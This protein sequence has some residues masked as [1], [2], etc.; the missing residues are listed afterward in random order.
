MTETDPS[1]PVPVDE[2]RV[3]FPDEWH[4]FILDRR[5]RGTPRAVTIEPDAPQRMKALF[6][7]RAERLD[8][9]IDGLDVPA[10]APTIRAGIAGEADPQ[11]AALALLMFA[12]VA[13]GSHQDFEDLGRDAWIVTHGFAFACRAAVEMLGY[14][15]YYWNRSGGAYGRVSV[16]EPD[17]HR[18]ALLNAHLHRIARL[19]SL[20]AALPEDEYLAVRD[21]IAAHRTTDAKKFGA[22]MLMPDQEDWV[23]EALDLHKGSKRRRYGGQEL[24][25]TIVSTPE[26]AERAGATAIGVYGDVPE[27]IALVVDALGTDA[28]PILVNTIEGEDRPSTEVRDLL[29]DAIGR[30]PT[31]A[32]LAYLLGDLTNPHAMAAAVQAARRFPVRTLRAVLTIAANAHAATKIRLAGFARANGLL[33]VAEALND[34]DRDR[35][36]ELV[37]R[38]HPV[39][40]TVPEVFTT[41]PWTPYTKPASK[42]AALALTPPDL[43]ELRWAPGQ[44]DKWRELSGYAAGYWADPARWSHTRDAQD[45]KDWAFNH[46]IAYAPDDRTRPL[47]AKWDGTSESLTTA[48]LK[49]ILARYGDE[50][51][52]HVMALLKRKTSFREALQ[53]FVNLDAARLAAGWLSRSRNERAAARAWLDQYP[54]DA[55]AFLIPDAV[56]K[57][58]KLRKAAMDALRHLDRSVVDERAAAYGEEAAEAVAALLDAD[59]FDPQLP[60]IPK[61]GAW[62]DPGA[63]PQVLLADRSAALPDAAVRTL[64]TALAMD[65]TERPYPGVDALA[66]ECEPESLAAFSW[67]LF[68]LWLSSGSPSKDAWA[69]DQLQRFADDYAVRHLTERIREWPGQSQNRKAVRGLE[70]LGGVGSEAALRA[71]HGIA[72]KAKFKALKKTATEQIEVIAERLELTLDQLGDRLVPDFGLA[73]E[74]LV[75]DYGPRSFTIKFDEALKPY[76]IDDQGKRKASAPKPNAKDDPELAGPAYER[77]AALRKELKATAAEQVKRLEGAMGTGRTWTAAEFQEF[78]I[79]HPL[80]WQLSS[81]LVWQAGDVAFRL[82]EDRTL[83]DAEDEPFELP[84]DAVV[85]LAHPLTLGDEVEVW[86]SVF[87]DYEILQP[88]DQLA[89]PAFALTEEERSTGV[90][91]RFMGAKAGG[92]PL[93]G[94]IKR[95]WK[96]GGPPG[97][98]GYGLYLEFAGGGY[99]YLDSKPGVHPGYGYDNAEEQT[100]EIV[101]LSIPEG[102]NVDPVAISE[103]INVIAKLIRSA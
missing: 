46:L 98:G 99:L 102:A 86:A 62:A 77:F 84:E 91:K 75:L 79:D 29:F 101:E 71:V 90:L 16:V 37:T 53:P 50:V 21:A 103:A 18:V 65:Q 92:G 36:A 44:Q 74:S 17:A 96:Y 31:D 48:T 42:R 87:A 89:R 70:V 67:G 27:R 2:D 80:M 11:G 10:Y 97:R 35:L 28:L 39:A 72:Q 7:E 83:A 100:L 15:V 41:P 93:I 63:L 19:R 1:I 81:R 22:A 55:A 85:R 51:K 49:P 13:P 6:A 43:D 88:F 52:A 24:V 60:R 76:V 47:L 68:E 78:L 66:A 5:G 82:A 12:Q 59:P 34:A 94:L 40:E 61:P 30:L 26:H 14:E 32:A 58:A 38:R 57:D 54:D 4:E 56:G 64:M 23:R 95:G 33:D 45:P 3:D 73:E 20:L 9:L 25:W 69:M 8:K